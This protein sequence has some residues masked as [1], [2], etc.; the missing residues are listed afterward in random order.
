MSQDQDALMKAFAIRRVGEINEWLEGHKEVPS[1]RRRAY[2]LTGEGCVSAPFHPTF[3][4][5]I[6]CLQYVY[7]RSRRVKKI[8]SSG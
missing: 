1:C 6:E 3:S 2:W 4:L 7:V 5:Y 8:L